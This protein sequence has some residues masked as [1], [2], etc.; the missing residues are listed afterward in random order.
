[1]A[2]AVRAQQ[3][4]AQQVRAQQTGHGQTGLAIYFC[5]AA[6]AASGAVSA[7]ALESVIDKGAEVSPGTLPRC[8]L[9]AMPPSRPSQLLPIP[10]SGAESFSH[11]EQA[12]AN[13]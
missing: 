11:R 9:K 10:C 4:K 3:V 12:R 6:P 2:W 5:G 1:M 8:A 13:T 7:A